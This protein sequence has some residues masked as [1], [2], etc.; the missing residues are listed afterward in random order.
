[1]SNTTKG[2]ANTNKSN[3]GKEM[4][5]LKVWAQ[6]AQGERTTAIE[7]VASITTNMVVVGNKQPKKTFA[8]I[9]SDVVLTGALD[10]ANSGESSPIMSAMPDDKKVNLKYAVSNAFINAVINSEEETIDLSK[11]I[12]EGVKNSGILN[13]LDL[14]LESKQIVVDKERTM[15][16]ESKPEF[17]TLENGTKIELVR[18]NRQETNGIGRTN[19]TVVIFVSFK[20]V[21]AQYYKKVEVIMPNFKI[22]KIADLYAGVKN[23]RVTKQM[24]ALEKS[25]PGMDWAI[26]PNGEIYSC[27]AL[28]KL[29]A[30]GNFAKGEVITELE[31][32]KMTTSQ[33][34]KLIETEAIALAVETKKGI[35]AMKYFFKEGNETPI[36][37]PTSGTEEWDKLYNA[38][39]LHPCGNVKDLGLSET[40]DFQNLFA[41]IF[42]TYNWLNEYIQDPKFATIA[43]KTDKMLGGATGATNI[44]FK[45]FTLSKEI[46]KKAT[47]FY[48]LAAKGNRYF[49]AGLTSTCKPGLPNVDF[50]A[51]FALVLL[52]KGFK[53]YSN[54]LNQAVVS[55]LDLAKFEFEYLVKLHADYNETNETALTMEAFLAKMIVKSQI[56]GLKNMTIVELEAVAYIKEQDKTE[57]IKALESAMG[58]LPIVIKDSEGKPEQG[59]W[60]FCESLLTEYF[61]GLNFNKPF[62]LELAKKEINRVLETE[63]Q[64]VTRTIKAQVLQLDGSYQEESLEYFIAPFSLHTGKDSLSVQ[65]KNIFGTTKTTIQGLTTEFIELAKKLGKEEAMNYIVKN[66][67]ISK[68]QLDIVLAAAG[69]TAVKGDYK[70]VETGFNLYVDH[71]N[72]MA[73]SFILN[74]ES[75]LVTNT[76]EADVM[77]GESTFNLGN[78]FKINGT[79][80]YKFEESENGS[81]VLLKARA[82]GNLYTKDEMQQILTPDQY[83]TESEYESLHLFFMDLTSK[84]LLRDARKHSRL[85]RILEGI[86]A[87][88]IRDKWM[89]FT[90][91]SK[92][93]NTVVPTEFK[94]AMIAHLNAKK[95]TQLTL[96]ELMQFNKKE[97][98]NKL[99]TMSNTDFVKVTQFSKQVEEI[100]DTTIS[101]VAFKRDGKRYRLTHD[102]LNET[103]TV[104][105]LIN[106]PM[107]ELRKSLLSKKA[108]EY[109]CQE[110]PRVILT[111]VTHNLED[112]NTVYVNERMFKAMK[113]RGMFKTVDGINW[114]L[115]KRYPETMTNG[116]NLKLE[117]LDSVADYSMLMSDTA[118][119]F[120]M[121][122][123]DGDTVEVTA[124]IL[125][126]FNTLNAKMLNHS[127][128][129]RTH[130]DSFSFNDSI[131][132][133][134][135]SFGKLKNEFNW[136]VEKAYQDYRMGLVL[137][138]G[139]NSL[140]GKIIAWDTK[141]TLALIEMD[142][143]LKLIEEFKC[144]LGAYV[145]QLTIASKN[146]TAEKLA[147]FDD[148]WS[149]FKKGTRNQQVIAEILNAV[150]LE[151]L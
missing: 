123:T 139:T 137:N 36:E 3:G 35:N 7:E 136:S 109:V 6:A 18:A 31:A 150:D 117:V 140:T 56:S 15:G 74:Y 49:N 126:G 46:N 64:T 110:R 146:N 71:S 149:I 122:D 22:V 14:A 112:I 118:L 27:Q 95:Q 55:A 133:F 12:L 13:E 108:K 38:N 42:L 73:N 33:F 77:V 105:H 90:C 124:P 82:E 141:I 93:W 138:G 10:K 17:L 26:T 78:G 58:W 28:V 89:I 61:N 113:F 65:G 34:I 88:P 50:G 135:K 87:F 103:A 1:M 66:R 44:E 47:S 40:I 2:F 131:A 9:Y 63:V 67:L 119:M 25:N 128:N 62:N 21:N 19:H 99:E 45:S 30:G 129:L 91:S 20:E 100:N 23:Q 107:L 130:Y 94:Q 57:A 102:F 111:V 68:R 147:T 29:I 80:I 125:A 79:K 11:P 83:L 115:A 104:N 53:H 76:D 96:E 98:L 41:N 101:K 142:A 51:A 132:K 54:R 52:R 120:L 59:F 43:F 5:E 69:Y 127:D 116:L 86:K 145:A 72:K 92:V 114:V 70:K 148:N 106:T 134:Y 97:Y 16:L 4:S 48:H 37:I 144:F 39:L 121:G 8:R 75:C 60:Y 81:V 85:V 32:E 84:D 24:I 143:D 151:I